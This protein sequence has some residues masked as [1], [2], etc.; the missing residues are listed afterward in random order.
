MKIGAQ[1]YTVRDFCKTPDEL[2]LTFKKI[3]DIGYKYVQL[4]G[5]CECE[6]NWLKS[7][8]EL[9]GLI[10]YITHNNGDKLINNTDK[11]IAE[12]KEL[13]CHYIGLGWYDFRSN[14]LSDFVEKFIPV[15]NRIK[16][17]GFQFMYHNHDFEFKKQNGKT[18]LNHLAENFTPK[19]M[20]FTLD[21]FW[22]QAGGCDPAKLICDLKGRVPCVHY[23]DMSYDRKM[24]AVGQG[25]MNWDSIIEASLKS[26]VEIAFV[27][28][29]D[30]GGEDPFECLK[31]SYDFLI[32]QGLKA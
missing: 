8:L 2:S 31:Q 15:A 9:N 19:Q 22:A 17:A 25:N 23:K 11:V 16:D 14:S 26:G 12:H 1:L 21:T 18:I 10:G 13:N 29:D 30:T 28:Q 32:A 20:G 5:I 27:E 24:E 4:S 6:A 7:Q 3:A